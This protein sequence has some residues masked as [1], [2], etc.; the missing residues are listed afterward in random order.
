MF[1]VSAV[2]LYMIQDSKWLMSYVNSKETCS[3]TMKFF[4]LL[5]TECQQCKKKYIYT[6]NIYKLRQFQRQHVKNEY[7]MLVD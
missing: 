1:P 6:T 7:I 4:L 3:P 5:S 2:L